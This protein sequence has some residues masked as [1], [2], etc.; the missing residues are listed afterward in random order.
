MPVTEL[1]LL[2]L[3]PGIEWPLA[4]LN[5]NLRKAKKVM[6]SASG[7]KFRYFRC[8]E[9]PATI[10]IFGEWPSVEFHM[11]TFIPSQENQELL[12]LLKDQVTVEWMF[13]LDIDQSHRPLPWHTSVI[14]VGRHFVADGEKESFEATFEANK[15]NL[16]AFIGGSDRVVGG[17]RI[18]KGVDPLLEG[19]LKSEYVLIS[20]WSS[21]EQHYQFAETEG[22]Q[23]YGQIRN[24]LAGVEIKHAVRVDLENEAQAGAASIDE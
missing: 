8:I 2:R 10:F 18:D 20:G 5:A 11:T 23:K 16:E 12:E 14:A 24:H 17:W 3:R 19:E 13:H 4:A 15:H 7:L 21:V 6:E 9:D 1:A 22:F